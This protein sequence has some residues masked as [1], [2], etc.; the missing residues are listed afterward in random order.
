MKTRNSNTTNIKN[1]LQK[2]NFPHC[3]I[4]KTSSQK[5]ILKNL[6][7]IRTSFEFD[8]LYYAPTHKEAPKKK[9]ELEQA[10]E[11][12]ERRAQEA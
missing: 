5:F 3:T 1:Q 11:E 6:S 8:V 9:S 2:L 7:G 4:N 10:K 12:A